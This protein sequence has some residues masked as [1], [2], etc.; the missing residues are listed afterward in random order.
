MFTLPRTRAPPRP[1]R[2]SLSR[3]QKRISSRRT[4][5]RSKSNS[6]TT[7]TKRT[8]LRRPRKAQVKPGEES[9]VCPSGLTPR[10]PSSTMR[11]TAR[12]V[13]GLFGSTSPGS[14]PAPSDLELTRRWLF[15]VSVSLALWPLF[16]YLLWQDVASEYPLHDPS[17]TAYK[18]A[19][20]I[21]A[22]RV[23]EVYKPGDLIFIH[24]CAFG[25]P[26]LSD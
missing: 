11:A 18:A 6:R 2:I 10:Q 21:F 15:S 22:K 24:D 4:R 25:F 19:N 23:A 12:L 17:F 14:Q 1:R 20:E 26:D 8:T 3:F 5:M 7:A 16:H 9:S 13:R